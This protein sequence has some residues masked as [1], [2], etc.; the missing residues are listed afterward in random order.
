ML[1][2][3]IR[4]LVVLVVLILTA[5]VVVHIV[6]QSR[7]LSDLILAEAGDAIGMNVTA[8]SVS[9]GWGG[10]TTI[11]NIAVAMPLNGGAALTAE[12]IE[13]VH[14]TVPSLIF[15]RAAS[16]RSVEVDGPQ[17][18]LHRSENGRWNVQDIWTRVQ[19]GRLSD[20]EKTEAVSLPEVV[21][22]NARISI[23]GPNKATRTVGPLDFHARSEGRLA[24]RFELEASG[25]A[26]V[27]GQ[28]AEGRDWAHKVDFSLVDLASLV[29]DLGGIDLS[30]IR[31]AGRWEGKV[32][33]DSVDGMLRLDRLDAGPLAAHGGLA[34]QIRPGQFSV[35][36][37][38]LVIAEPNAVGREVRLSGGP[39]RLLDGEIRV[40]QLAVSSGPII[41]Q[42]SGNWDLSGRSGE[43]SGFWATAAGTQGLRSNGTY[44]AEVQAPRF[45]RKAASVSFSGE[46]EDSFGEVALTIEAEGGGP[47]WRQSQ[48][49]VSTPVLRWSRR[50]KRV[51]LAEAAAE[52]RVVWPQVHL[53]D[54]RVPGAE[55]TEANAVFNASDRRW[56]TR[57][58][59]DGVPH[60]AVWGF[61]SVDLRL[62]AAGDDHKAHITELRMSEGDRIVAAE[63]DL[64]FHERGFQDVR[65][66]AEWP[67]REAQ[68]GQ[69][70]ARHSI[71]QWRLEG[72][73]FGR[74]LPPTMEMAGRLTGRSVSLGKLTVDRIEV[75]IRVK[76]DAG[77][78]Q[79][80]TDPVD[81]FGGRW[82]VSGRH[83]LA[84]NLT[85]VTAT[86]EALSLESVAAMAGVKLVSRGRAH[87]EIEVAVRDFDIQS[88]VAAGSWD[89]EDVNIPP[90][91]AER[92][93]GKLRIA[94]GQARLDE[95]LLEQEGGRAW[96]SVQFRP[97]KPEVL[98]VELSARQ[99]PAT[100]EGESVRMLADGTAHLRV[101]LVNR[102]A[103]GEARLSGMVLLDDHDF[104]R[105][106]MSALVQDQ[107]LNVEE[108]YA[109][110][111]GG[112]VEGRARLCLGR[113]M[114]SSIKVRWQ[115]I[116]PNALQPWLPLSSRFEGFV[117]GFFDVEPVDP[118][119]RPPEP[120]RFTLDT[121]V[122]DGWFGAASIHSLR[123]TG[124]LGDTRLLV[125]RAD[126]RVFDG[127][128]TARAR[129]STHA[130]ARYGNLTADFNHVNLDQIVHVVN[131]EAMQHAGSLSGVV[132]LLGSSA[133]V[134]KDFS[135]L[136]GEAK[137]SLTKSD[138]VNNRVIRTLYDTLS[139]QFGRQE[140]TG[141]GDV[142]IR[143]EGSSLLIP[144]FV[145]FNRG[146][147]VRGAGRI[148]NLHRGGL[149]EVD[150]FA[151][152]ST[153]ILKGVNLPGVRS[154]DRLL[155]TFQ[156]GAS[157]VR[158]GGTLEHTEVK[159]VPLPVVLD[160]FRRLLW[161]QLRQ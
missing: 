28:V 127:E 12:R 87:A 157:S 112:T 37:K 18:S 41:A 142:T 47:D 149:S 84:A 138:L 121:E 27:Q 32:V 148:A 29:H 74:I 14:A 101:N 10:R 76:A 50:D 136:Q 133:A 102:T 130:G 81:M 49:R 147:E 140:P 13:V 65:L 152:A 44:R 9:L 82:Q 51:D 103:D 111:L 94:E 24:W 122:E 131:P 60:L 114:G 104:A 68:S 115:G 83:D 88:A 98:L 160:P 73:V 154:L 141:T 92:M 72:S 97:D 70:Q 153:R 42:V 107:T 155:A 66:Y 69:L 105:V 16:V 126:L 11:R 144:T 159:V 26:G 3:T 120:M 106:N 34:V 43:F 4:I 99:W 20:K 113:W 48:W 75:P 135:P 156:S 86:A 145:Y 137:I 109:E 90:L 58:A 23:E 2:W 71:G 63:G 15:G 118:A 61:K 46:A 91:Q 35:T 150:G 8:D 146:V 54:L 79:M 117:S 123:M 55:V 52:V 56:S 77:I 1:R 30:P 40:E 96:A 5:A 125:D 116:R 25:I 119:D 132:T 64:S 36:A 95:I 143:L 158:I 100:F 108:F 19:A 22:R 62:N 53:A 134:A 67:A 124:F 93:R 80:A 6:L 39:I 151:V 129:I 139:L 31:A 7:W 57:M 85:Q 89:A 161:T 59:V 17:V 45:G 21:I 78:V 33:Q 38:D 128:V 110:T